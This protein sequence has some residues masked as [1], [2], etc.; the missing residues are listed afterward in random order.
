MLQAIMPCQNHHPWRWADPTNQCTQSPSRSITMKVQY[1]GLTYFYKNYLVICCFIH[2]SAPLASIRENSLEWS[3]CQCT[4]LIPEGDAFVNYFQTTWL[5]SN[6]PLKTW[7]YQEC[8]CTITWKD[9]TTGWRR[10]QENLT[11]NIAKGAG[12]YGGDH[13]AVVRSRKTLFKE[14]TWCSTKKWSR[15]WLKN[16]LTVL[17]QSLDSFLSSI[18]HCVV[19]FDY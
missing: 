12:C 6:F 1:L 18:C 3:Q 15:E 8:P 17:L 11:R 10:Q 14:K 16:F 2:K 7:N 13:P 4:S 19:S 9:D 5:D